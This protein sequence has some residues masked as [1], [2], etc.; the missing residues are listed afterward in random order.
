MAITVMQR[1]ELKYLLTA[2]QTDFLREN[3][4]GHME[5]D[6]YGKTSIASLYYDTPN[7]QL[8]RRSVEKPEFKEKIRLRSYGLATDTSPVFLELKRKAYGVVYKRR[9]ETRIPL[10]R[11]FFSGEGG[12]CAPGQ[13]NKEITVF[14]D[15]HKTLVPTCLIIYD[16][17]AYFEPDGDLRLTIDENPR[18]RTD[19]LTLTSS[20]DGVSLLGEGWTVLEVKV[21]D[22]VPLWLSEILAKGDIAMR[23]F[24]K[25]GEAYR[26]QLVNAKAV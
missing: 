12:L 19:D 4:K 17:T 24:S 25:Y 23:S 16:R 20:M 10:V 1:Y 26:R 6:Q 14:R 3:L 15:Y 18:Y 21:Q 5:I 7:C 8:I 13:I 22:A 11:E 2:E 9:V